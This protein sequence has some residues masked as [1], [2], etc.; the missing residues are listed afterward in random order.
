MQSEALQ[1]LGVVDVSTCKT[2]RNVDFKDI[3]T[4]ENLGNNLKF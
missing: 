2:G 3:L 4:S 1:V